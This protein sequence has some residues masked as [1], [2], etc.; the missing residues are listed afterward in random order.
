MVGILLCDICRVTSVNG[1][2]PM[3]ERHCKELMETYLH[4]IHDFSQSLPFILSQQ[5]HT[6]ARCLENPVIN[7]LEEM[8]DVMDKNYWYVDDRPL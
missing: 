5:Q 2:R 4:D 3:R 6:Q 7:C 1:Y 8:S